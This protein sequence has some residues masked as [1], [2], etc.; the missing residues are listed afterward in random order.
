MT[1]LVLTLLL[2][3]VAG[4]PMKTGQA[5][6][7]KN[8][9]TWPEKGTILSAPDPE[10]P[11]GFGKH[12][13]YIDA[14]HGV[15]ENT[16]TVSAF[17]EDEQEHNLRIAKVLAM[18]LE[19]TGHFKVLLSRNTH[20]GP[21]YKQRIKQAAKFN[22]QVII[23]LHSDARG[24]AFW[25]VPAPGKLCYRNQKDPGFA[26]LWSDSGPKQLVAQRQSLARQVAKKMQLTGFLPYDGNDYTG[27]YEG[28]PD[29]PG[30]FVDRHQ[31]GER[32][33]FL[34]KPVIPS[35][36]IETH[37]ALD[38]REDSLYRESKTQEAFAK[39]ITAAL[40]A[41]LALK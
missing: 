35:V 34:R 37:H 27:L 18:Y 30:V 9:A 20:D 29:H 6:S 14:G 22:A 2:V 32:I 1:R 33:F 16:G 7:K 38:T 40:I 5:E 36:I 25:W 13:V 39:T 3:V 23:S 8:N 10:F 15:L 4:V 21:S 31:P 24:L 12:I 28:D 19:K 17:C 41:Y 11:K 26:I